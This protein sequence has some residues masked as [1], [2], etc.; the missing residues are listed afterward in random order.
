M[1]YSVDEPVHYPARGSDKTDFEASTRYLGLPISCI[2]DLG[3]QLGMGAFVQRVP[4]RCGDMEQGA[5]LP[6]RS[7][8]KKTDE[9][10][11]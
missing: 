1:D 2:F 8:V 11:C 4:G 10:K 6:M 5:E 7:N 9:G 3:S